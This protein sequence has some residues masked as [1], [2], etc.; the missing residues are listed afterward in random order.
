MGPVSTRICGPNLV[1]VRRSCRKK[2]GGTG[3]QAD[4]QTKISAALYNRYGLLNCGLPA[5]A[6]RPGL[7]KYNEYGKY[8]LIICS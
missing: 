2:R 5:V 7:L 4:R 3:R 8:G 6:S 1:A